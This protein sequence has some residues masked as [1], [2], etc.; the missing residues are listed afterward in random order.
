M[1]AAMTGT[2]RDPQPGSPA[3]ATEYVYGGPS[4]ASGWAGWVVFAGVMLVLIGSFH[5]I[6][7]VVALFRDEVYL[8]RPGGLVVEIG[9][10]TW[11]WVH[12]IVG[13]AA[14]LTGFGLL[15]GN[16]VARFVGVV[17]ALLSAV[18]NLAFIRAQPVW[19]LIAITLDL[20]VIYAITVHGRELRAPTY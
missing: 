1:G 15:A 18:L 9:Y 11:G 17:L 16:I 2:E 14:L 4:A 5:A 19:A 20:I 13:I 7:G 12:V 8:V 3:P 10:T 6:E